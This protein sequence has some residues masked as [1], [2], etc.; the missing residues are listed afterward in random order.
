MLA[1]RAVMPKVLWRSCTT[2]MNKAY[3]RHA[4][5]AAGAHLQHYKYVAE[6]RTRQ[7]RDERLDTMRQVN[8]SQ[9][10]WFRQYDAQLWNTCESLERNLPTFGIHTNNNAE[11]F[12]N[13]LLSVQGSEHSLRSLTAGPLIK[14]FMNLF[15]TQ[16]H[17]NREE[18]RTLDG[19]THDM[20]TDSALRKLRDECTQRTFYTSREIGDGRYEVRR[21]DID[22][23]KVRTVKVSNTS[24]CGLECSCGSDKD[25]LKACRHIYRVAFDF[26]Q[27]AAAASTKAAADMFRVDKYIADF[28]DFDV[29]LPDHADIAA[30]A[31]QDEFPNGLVLPHI[32]KGRGRPRVN[33]IQGNSDCAQLAPFNSSL[34]S[35]ADDL[36]SAEPEEAED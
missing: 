7:E 32:E 4:G 6:A 15:V 17:E 12:C 30:C 20:F 1:A 23:E 31:G 35:A 11:T 28:K 36:R 24:F 29:R 5:R 18:A 22:I 10:E 26:P 33:R 21:A 2:H 3:K 25:E 9:Y 14:G 27:H 13:K 34:G 8:P 16:A 19:K